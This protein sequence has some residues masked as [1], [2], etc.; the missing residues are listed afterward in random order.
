MISKAFLRFVVFTS[1]MVVMPCAAQTLQE[2]KDYILRE[3]PH[4]EGRTHSKFSWITVQGQ[5]CLAVQRKTL[6]EGTRLWGFP[7]ENIDVFVAKTEYGVDLQAKART[8]RPPLGFQQLGEDGKWGK[9]VSV[10]SACPILEEA[11]D[12]AKLNKLEKAFNHLIKLLTG[13]KELF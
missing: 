13:R 1:A 3:L 6:T 5:L 4:C 11:E 10:R 7:I 12:I 9:P 2:T 8:G